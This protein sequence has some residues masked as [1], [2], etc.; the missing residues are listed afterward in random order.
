MKWL[1]LFLSDFK[2]VRSPKDILS[3]TVSYHMHMSYLSIFLSFDNFP[4]TNSYFFPLNVHFLSVFY[5]F[6]VPL[7]SMWRVALVDYS[8]MPSYTTHFRLN[9]GQ[10]NSENDHG[11]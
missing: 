9:V 11:R 8:T 6:P 2:N 1:F 10:I 5:P 3:V 4:P 7:M